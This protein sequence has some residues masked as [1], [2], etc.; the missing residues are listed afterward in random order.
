MLLQRPALC[1]LL[2]NCL[3]TPPS[4]VDFH[5]NEGVGVIDTP[6]RFGKFGFEVTQYPLEPS[7]CDTFIRGF[8]LE[9]PLCLS[10]VGQFLDV[11]CLSV[12]Q[13]LQFTFC[14]SSSPF[15]G[16]DTVLSKWNAPRRGVYWGEGVEIFRT[17]LRHRFRF[18]LAINELQ[19]A[20]RLVKVCSGCLGFGA[21]LRTCLLP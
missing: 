12:A 11:A 15:I 1:P 8:F 14:T 6:L 21:V 5:A 4:C 9:A 18:V 13:E 17:V 2:G 20:A 10:R 7:S 19:P 3:F 16:C